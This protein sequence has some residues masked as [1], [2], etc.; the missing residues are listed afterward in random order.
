MHCVVNCVCSST[1]VKRAIKSFTERSAINN[2]SDVDNDRQQSFDLLRI[3]IKRMV[4]NWSYLL[5][6]HRHTDTQTYK[7][8]RTH[9]SIYLH[10]YLLS[11]CVAIDVT[12][13]LLYLITQRDE[14]Y[15]SCSGPTP[16]TSLRRECNGK[17]F[18][19][20]RIWALSIE[21]AHSPPRRGNHS[22]ACDW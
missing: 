17:G 18:S 14:R 22:L 15:G 16:T 5:S 21:W 12:L 11:T 13:Y 20:K 1:E 2:S 9:A 10:I 3:V 7:H 4:I 6:T 19:K 8:T